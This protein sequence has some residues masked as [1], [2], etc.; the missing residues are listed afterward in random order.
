MVQKNHFDWLWPWVKD[1]PLRRAIDCGA[2]KGYW[3]MEW[4]DKIETIECFEPNTEILTLFKENTAHLKNINLYEHALGDKPGTVAMDYETH[5]GTYHI[6]SEQGPHEIKTLD[7]YNF[8]DVDIIKI[9]VEG[10]EIPL[11]DGARET[12][13]NNKPWI[14][15][16]ANETGKKFY[17]RPKKQIND[18][19]ASFGMKRRA[20]EWPDQIWSF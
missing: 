6:I 18:K 7:T 17:D 12:I 20:K 13:M 19:L 1:M 5:V 16:E 10:Y 3:T 2:H 14:Q 9:D 8:T 15:I 4:A 11:L